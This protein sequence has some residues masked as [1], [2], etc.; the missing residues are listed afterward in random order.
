[1]DPFQLPDDIP[2]IPSG[3]TKPLSKNTTKLYRQL[4]KH[5]A[6]QGYKTRQDLLDNPDKVLEH[7]VTLTASPTAKETRAKQRQYLSAIMYVMTEDY[8]KKPNAYYTFFQKAKDPESEWAQEY[9]D[10]K[11]NFTIDFK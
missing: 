9:R 5:F 1:M 3:R 4:L 2:T 8:K 10:K 6:K 11:A 7:M